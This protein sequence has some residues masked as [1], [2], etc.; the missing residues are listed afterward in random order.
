MDT[1]QNNKKILYISIGLAL[2]LLLLIIYFSIRSRKPGNSNGQNPEV[3]TTPAITSLPIT[4]TPTVF[5]P[6]PTISQKF[7]GPGPGS[8]DVLIDQQTENQFEAV[9]NLSKL[10]PYNGQYFSIQYVQPPGDYVV[11]IPQANKEQGNAEFESF[12]N[13]N[14]IKT[15]ESIPNLS[16]VYQ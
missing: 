1:T 9:A 5:I 11:T 8:S 15:K 7:D 10:V 13:K 4:F 6:S 2:I 12:L 14:N 16:I 3:T